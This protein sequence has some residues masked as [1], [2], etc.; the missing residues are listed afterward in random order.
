MIGRVNH[1][2]VRLF[3]SFD[4]DLCSFYFRYCFSFVR[5]AVAHNSTFFFSFFEYLGCFF[6]LVDWCVHSIFNVVPLSAALF[7]I[8]DPLHQEND[9][10]V[11]DATHI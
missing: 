2:F 11:L 4:C 6:A 7:Q 10:N 8:E 3:I 9:E 1:F 5:V